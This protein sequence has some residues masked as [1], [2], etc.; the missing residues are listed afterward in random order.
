[1]QT[2][3]I[4]TTNLLYLLKPFIIL[5]KEAEILIRD[6]YFSVATMFSMLL[7]RVPTTTKSIFVDLRDKT[8][9]LL[10]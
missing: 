6:I 2:E 10:I 4:F 8:I 3:V 5:Q 7:N 9:K 1:M